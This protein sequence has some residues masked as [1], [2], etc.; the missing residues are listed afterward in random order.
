MKKVK[1]TILCTSLAVCVLGCVAVPFIMDKSADVPS[2]DLSDAQNI[3][4]SESS[5]GLNVSEV[6]PENKIEPVT[7]SKKE[8]TK[9]DIFY[10]ML[11]AQFNYSSVTGK[12]VDGE[13]NIDKPMHVEFSANLV[14]GESYEKTTISPVVLNENY[15]EMSSVKVN[16]VDDYETEECIQSDERF[17]KAGKEITFDNIEEVK[18]VEENFGN[19]K[20]SDVFRIDDENRIMEMEDGEK[21]YGYV[22]NPT[23]PG[24]ARICIDP[25]EMTYGFLLDESLWEVT[26]ETEYLKRNCYVI[27]GT[28]EAD[29][30]AKLNVDKFKFLVDTETGVLLYYIGYDADGNLSDYMYAEEISFDYDSQKIDNLLA[31][32]EKCAYTLYEPEIEYYE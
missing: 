4:Y 21:A 19:Y 14:D 13:L 6:V 1:A 18:R 2:V 5:E 11:N 25:Q 26:D 29:Y 3:D 7:E 22:S 28:T 24:L 27:E 17:F 8:V 31:E 16:I 32:K 9:K 23:I 15:S 30:G 12:I 10:M 20:Q